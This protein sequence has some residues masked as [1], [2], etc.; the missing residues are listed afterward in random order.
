MPQIRFTTRKIASLPI[1]EAG[2]LD[3]FSETEP[4]FAVRVSHG[5]S[6][7][8][9]V[10][11][12]HDGRQRR[13]SLGQFPRVGGDKERNQSLADARREMLAIKADVAKGGDPAAKR[14]AERKAAIEAP[15]FKMLTDEFL[16]RYAI[17][18]DPDEPNKRS[19]REDRR[20][21][22]TYLKDWHGRK[23]ASV[24]RREVIALLDE[25]ADR[26]PVMANRVLSL[27]RK[28]YN[29][30]LDKDMVEANPAHKLTPPGG[31]EQERDRV[32]NPDEIR[33]LW[34]AFDGPAGDIYRLVLITGQRA[35]AEIAGMKWS[36]I[37]F[38]NALWTVPAARMKSK[39]I[40][41]VP[42]ASM[43]L[44][45]LRNVPRLD[46]EFVFPSP[47]RPDQ[48]IKNLGKAAERV[49]EASGVRDF[50]SHDLRRTAGT[51]ITSLGFSR[52]IMDR[53]LG[54]LEPGVGARYDRH[55]Y[56]KEKRAAL[57]SWGRKLQEIISGEPVSAK[58]VELHAQTQ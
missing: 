43:A 2:Q 47:T 25:I 38:D 58:M 33:K 3:Y 21:I 57:R 45:V 15:T 22:E 6:K 14:Q 48:P 32:Y 39:R 8:F 20:I 44:D 35:R 30:A 34:A 37:D 13:M 1:P 23:A 16:K 24:T 10:K 56:L 18:R 19:W 46:D 36:E 53:C 12:V 29:Y 7:T 9:F 17:G 49:K 28:V 31:K 5:G 40:H 27:V 41:V 55:D 51:G 42:L 4:G 54:H 11:Y 26:A 52:F 50:R